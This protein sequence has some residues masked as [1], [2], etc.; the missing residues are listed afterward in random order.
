MCATGH[1]HLW[2][3]AAGAEQLL[4]SRRIRKASRGVLVLALWSYGAAQKPPDTAPKPPDALMISP[5]N[6]A[7]GKQSVASQSAPLEITLRNAS[8]SAIHF[9]QILSS[10]IDFG[11]RNNCGNDLP[12][13]AQCTVQVTFKPVI[14]G[15]RMG[16]IEIAASDAGSPHYVPLQGTGE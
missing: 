13:G 6:V 3:K 8:N 14:S 9:T 2:R 4:I 11:S 16:A 5:S 12:A 7:F 1:G 10:G 15:D